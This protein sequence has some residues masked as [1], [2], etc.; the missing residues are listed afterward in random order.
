MQKNTF[1]LLDPAFVKKLYY[2]RSMLS[3]S[4]FE[5]LQVVNQILML[6]EII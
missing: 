5:A 3:T 4:K 2:A 1:R 6:V